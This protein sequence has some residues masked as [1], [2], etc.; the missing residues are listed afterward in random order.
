[1]NVFV[2]LFVYLVFNRTFS[3]NR[4]YRSHHKGRKIYHVGA[5][6]NRNT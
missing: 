1:M 5:G 2:I 3:T 4:L 6:G